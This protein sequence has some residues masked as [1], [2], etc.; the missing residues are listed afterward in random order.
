MPFGEH[1]DKP[2]SEVPACYLHW[3]WVNGKKEDASCPVSAYIK[4]N[5][6]ALKEEFPDGIWF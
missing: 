6:I 5:L 2:M 1:E 4:R 3:L